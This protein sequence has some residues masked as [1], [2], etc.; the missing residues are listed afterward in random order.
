[1]LSLKRTQVLTGSIFEVITCVMLCFRYRAE[2]ELEAMS[3]S[4]AIVNRLT[5]TACRVTWDHRH[6][7]L[8]R[9]PLENAF[10]GS[11]AMI[12]DQLRH[13]LDAYYEQDLPGL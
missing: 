9:N 7:L 2:R 4:L 12:E 6:R 8:S 1:M 10:T 13:M 11:T 5:A 3:S